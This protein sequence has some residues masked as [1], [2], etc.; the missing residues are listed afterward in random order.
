MHWRIEIV[1]IG[2]E[3]NDFRPE[4]S[5]EI[6][7]RSATVMAMRAALQNADPVLLE[8][9]MRLEILTPEEYMGD[10]LGDTNSR[11]GKILDIQA[12]GGEQIIH[13]EVPLERLFGYAT[14]VRS[15]SKGRAVYSMEP[16]LFEIVPPAQ[17]D[18]ILHR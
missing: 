4:E 5:T 3:V 7:F 1:L 10:I 13:A 2:P 18:K 11:R 6:A 17:Q 8:P 12:N 14:D 16:H 9:V 15:L